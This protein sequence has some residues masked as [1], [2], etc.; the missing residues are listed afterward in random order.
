MLRFIVIRTNLLFMR[1]LSSLKFFEDKSPD[2]RHAQISSK[3]VWFWCSPA[4]ANAQTQGSVSL[5]LQTLRLSLW[6]GFLH[7]VMSTRC[8]H[9]RTVVSSRPVWWCLDCSALTLQ[10][11]P[12]YINVRVSFLS[13]V[14]PSSGF[15]PF[16]SYSS[17][18]TCT[19]W[20]RSFII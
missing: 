7:M 15:F 2:L 1:A 20:Q 18:L 10:Y 8:H 13:S 3:E 12:A 5:V 4:S 17:F 16:S 11:M 19:L 9:R 14:I 6:G